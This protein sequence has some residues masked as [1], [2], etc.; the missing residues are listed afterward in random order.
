MVDRPQELESV[1]GGK[2][3]TLFFSFA[4]HKKK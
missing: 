1:K 3:S 4:I 2:M